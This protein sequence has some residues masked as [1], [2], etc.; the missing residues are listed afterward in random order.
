MSVVC[1]DLIGLRRPDPLAVD[2]FRRP[3]RRA[4]H[5]RED[6]PIEPEPTPEEGEG[7]KT[8]PANPRAAPDGQHQPR[9]GRES[10]ADAPPVGGT[11]ARVIVHPENAE[12]RT[13][14]GPHCLVPLQARL[15]LKG[16][17]MATTT[18]CPHPGHATLINV[19]TVAPERQRELVDL[20]I[21]ATEQV[22]QHVPGFISANIHASID[23]TR[24]VN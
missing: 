14:F 9:D 11:S 3:R 5:R 24:V 15:A 22:I 10:P 23:G 7:H 1:R 6:P 20:L 19:F 2:A 16:V 8:P 17:S 13:C 18:I 21:D 4:V 12:Y